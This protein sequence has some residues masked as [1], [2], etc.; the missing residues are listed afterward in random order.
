M[1]N[2]VCDKGSTKYVCVQ[3]NRNLR[4]VNILQDNNITTCNIITCL[5]RAYQGNL[6]KWKRI[7]VYTWTV[8]IYVWKESWFTVYFSYHSKHLIRRKMLAI[9]SYLWKYK[10]PLYNYYT[11]IIY[12]IRWIFQQSFII[13]VVLN[14]CCWNV[15]G[16]N[17]HSQRKYIYRC[18]DKYRS[19]CRLIS[20]VPCFV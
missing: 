17:F 9:Q 12:S 14:T 18:I 19:G 1:C 10:L 5:R 8:N 6:Y 13:K 7:T 20:F 2:F 15:I 4:H 16:T 11:S 3:K